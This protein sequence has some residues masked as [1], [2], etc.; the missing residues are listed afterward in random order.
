MVEQHNNP[1]KM[2]EQD[3]PPIGYL[4]KIVAVLTILFIASLIFLV[5]VFHQEVR[6]AIFNKELSVTNKE[7]EK[8]NE[9]D[10]ARLSTYAEVSKDKGLY[11][12]PV[13]KVFDFLVQNPNRLGAIKP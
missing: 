5:F 13:D 11:Q 9:R 3:H 2:V 10:T 8:I 7:L 1:R 12:I 6:K 4:F